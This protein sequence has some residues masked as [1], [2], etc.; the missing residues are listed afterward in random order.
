MISRHGPAA[1]VRPVDASMGLLNEIVRRPVEPEYA[2][3]AARAA[4]DGGPEPTERRGGTVV[5]T[6]AVTV[7]LGLGLSAAAVTLRTPDQSV[8]DGRRLLEEEVTSRSARANELEEQIA[9]LNAEIAALQQTALAQDGSNI[10]DVLTRYQAA[11]GG[12]VVTGPGLLVVLHDAPEA[13]EDPDGA[14][15]DS[16]VQD[17][18]LQI[19]TNG[20]W[21]A[22]AEA[23]AINGHRL[24]ASSAIRSAG[25]AILV[26]LEPMIG[27]YRVEAIG[28]PADLQTGLATSAA[29]RH[30][31]LLRDTYGIVTE[32]AVRDDLLLAA[33]TGT[34]LRH[35]APD[36]SGNHDIVMPSTTPSPSAPAAFRLDPNGERSAL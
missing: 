16:F 11:A 32:A 14:D 7:L 4:R 19:L 31:A 34:V 9:D 10:L 13:Q 29:G 3:A 5:A 35:A 18:D 30:L 8:L 15:H 36:W 27:P 21:S 28:S 12:T 1:T 22:G 26:D 6:L 2:E 23:V 24:T 25:Q 20:L 17:L 33:A